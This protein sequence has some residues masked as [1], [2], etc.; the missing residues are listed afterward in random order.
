L[1]LMIEYYF[2]HL[3]LYRAD[4]MKKQKRGKPTEPILFPTRPYPHSPATSRHR[5]RLSPLAGDLDPLHR[6]SSF[7]STVS[8]PLLF[9]CRRRPPPRP[10]ARR[11]LA[12]S[13]RNQRLMLPPDACAAG[14]PHAPDPRTCG[15]VRRTDPRLGEG[16]FT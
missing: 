2:V 5:R 12:H 13:P 11:H 3:H 7:S 15:S 8:A 6:R 10:P 4:P 16:W 9:H 14:A 1:Q